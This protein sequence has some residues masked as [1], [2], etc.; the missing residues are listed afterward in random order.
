MVI[1]F[2]QSYLLA[3]ELF[4]IQSLSVATVFYGGRNETTPV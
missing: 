1:G 3:G 2:T 4:I